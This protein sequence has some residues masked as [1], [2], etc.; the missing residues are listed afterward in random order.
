[1]I[2]VPKGASAVSTECDATSCLFDSTKCA[3]CMSG[4]K[5]GKTATGNLLETVK[6]DMLLLVT[7]TQGEC[8]DT[9]KYGKWLWETTYSGSTGYTTCVTKCQDDPLCIKVQW[10][11]ATSKCY[12]IGTSSGTKNVNVEDVGY[13][14]AIKKQITRWNCAQKCAAKAGCKSFTWFPQ[15]GQS[16]CLLRDGAAITDSLCP[17]AFPYL[18]KYS[19]TDAWFCYENSNQAGGVCSYAGSSTLH[20]WSASQTACDPANHIYGG[21]KPGDDVASCQCGVLEENA[22]STCLEWDQCGGIVCSPAYSPFCVLRENLENLAETPTAAGG[23][24]S[25]S[26]THN[27]LY[28]AN[29]ARDGSTDSFTHTADGDTNPW[30]K[31]TFS[32]PQNINSVK[33][34]NRAECCGSRLNGAQVQIY[35]TNNQWKNCGSVISGAS[36]GDTHSRDCTG[37]NQNEPVTVVKISIPGSGQI[38]S[39]AEVVVS[40]TAKFYLVNTDATGTVDNLNEKS[41]SGNC[42]TCGK[43]GYSCDASLSSEKNCQVWCTTYPGCTGIY[44]SEDGTCCP[45]NAPPTFLVGNNPCATVVE[46]GRKP[47]T[48]FNTFEDHSSKADAATYG[49]ICRVSSGAYTCPTDKGNQWSKSTYDNN[50]CTKGYHQTCGQ[51][52][53][54]NL[55]ETAGGTWIPKDYSTN[56]YTCGMPLSGAVAGAPFVLVSFGWQCPPSCIK[57]SHAPWC[58]MDY[59]GGTY[60]PCRGGRKGKYYQKVLPSESSQDLWT[61]KIV[62]TKEESSEWSHPRESVHPFTGLKMTRWNTVAVVKPVKD[63]GPAG[64]TSS[65]PCNACEGDCDKDS[66]CKGELK[67]YQRTSSDAIV[68]GCSS[69]GYVKSTADHDYCYT[70]SN[71]NI[72]KTYI[73]DSTT[74]EAIID[75]SP[76]SGIQMEYVPGNSG[77]IYQNPAE[78]KCKTGGSWTRTK[79]VAN[80]KAGVEDCAALCLARGD[81]YFG[82]ECP[83][84]TVHCQCARSKADLGSKADDSDCTGSYSVKQHCV[85]PYVAGGYALGG[86]ERGSVYSTKS[87]VISHFGKHGGLLFDTN[88]NNI[89]LSSVAY[90]AL[91]DLGGSG[92]TSS[93]PCNTCEGDCDNDAQCKGSLKCFQR[94]L[95]TTLVPNCVAGGAGDVPT[96]DYCYENSYLYNYIPA[97]DVIRW[98]EEKNS[99]FST[100]CPAAFP[101]AS[102]RHNNVICYSDVSKA[103]AGTGPCNSWCTLDVAMG[104]GCGSNSDRLCGQWRSAVGAYNAIPSGANPFLNEDAITVAGAKVKQPFV[105]GSY[106]SRWSFGLIKG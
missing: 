63:L 90:R 36:D 14:C 91:K 87:S 1:M 70:E 35:T 76:G 37:L 7:S 56:P 77:W 93:S 19:N 69:T 99:G 28:L 29:K 61:Y 82:L 106:S 26:T 84:S 95:S 74:K 72:G 92:C 2:A 100:K 13:G 78:M 60:K 104:S 3:S 5:V 44:L 86:H 52:C 58:G 81:A 75:F 22:K 47:P 38:L 80:S 96:H 9:D 4:G 21:L 31:L 53:A 59:H 43:F 8:G 62:S 32:S 24:A 51:A 66:E 20:T 79:D 98:S 34:T 89:R 46:V 54:K 105:A 42:A 103:N 94:E 12:G 97:L 57:L 102:P 49:D 16:V 48:T 11:I 6:A 85:G 18:L 23:T 41:A 39:L 27:P 30:W 17:R 55:C 50:L 65:N 101:F 64:C 10:K 45:L 83:R 15:G 68:P 71:I 73:F 67:C 40:F 88:T 33:I 25:Q